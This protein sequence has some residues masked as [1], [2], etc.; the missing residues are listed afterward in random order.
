MFAY[1]DYMS[2]E[3]V[4]KWF[5]AV[6]DMPTNTNVP[7]VVPQ[8]AVEKRGEEFATEIMAFFR[9]QAAVTTPMW[10]S[11][12]QSFAND[13]LNAALE[14]IATKQSTP[15][16]ALAEAQQACQAELESVLAG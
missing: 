14:R 6:P 5:A 2:V 10:D 12:I 8:I 9:E 16:D 11:P 13:Q 7:E 15:Q 3:G 4:Q 1:F